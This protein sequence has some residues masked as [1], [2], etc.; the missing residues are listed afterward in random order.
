MMAGMTRLSCG[1]VEIESVAADRD[2]L[3]DFALRFVLGFRFNQDLV[4]QSVRADLW[5]EKAGGRRRVGTLVP[6]EPLSPRRVDGG[7]RQRR[8]PFF[9]PLSASE[10]D[11]LDGARAGGSA[12]LR[13]RVWV[14]WSVGEGEDFETDALIVHRVPMSDW[15]DLMRDAGFCDVLPVIIR[16]PPR[17]DSQPLLAAA[18]DFL[19]R[20]REE[21]SAGRRP[22]EAIT[23]AR[24]ALEAMTDWIGD[25]E[26]LKA[27]GNK[28]FANL[29]EMDLAQRLQ[30][31]RR[32]VKALVDPSPHGDGDS[33]AV[34]YDIPTA[35][36][37]I[38][39]VHALLVA[40][41]DVDS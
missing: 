6:C 34:S 33:I 41:L 17:Q 11:A 3:V 19:R 24:Q 15:L 36:A 32:G 30:L 10:M 12:E 8:W 35:R 31:V 9:L 20:A 5:T 16:L 40:Q 28:G 13:L 1:A 39:M 29:R 38:A 4:V 18:V 27:I 25:K 7:A 14:S 21:L 22:R 26:E 2:R 23:L 37:A